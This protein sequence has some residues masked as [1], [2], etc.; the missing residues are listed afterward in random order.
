MTTTSKSA[1]STDLTKPTN[2]TNQTSAVKAKATKKSNR[3]NQRIK[4]ALSKTIKPLQPS[5]DRYGEIKLHLDQLMNYS[6]DRIHYFKREQ[7]MPAGLGSNIMLLL[8]QAYELVF[9]IAAYN[10]DYNRQ[11]GLRK[12]SIKL[13]VLAANV[14]AAYVAKQITAQKWEIWTRYIVAVDDMA[15]AMAMYLQKHHENSKDQAAG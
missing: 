3:P 10:P 5:V 14:R 1:K 8:E 13:K 11:V 4:S 15:I 7:K 2:L 12:L 6:V 9:E